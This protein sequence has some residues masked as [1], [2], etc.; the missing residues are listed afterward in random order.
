VQH[1]LGLNGISPEVMLGGLL[2]AGAP[3][4]VY[5]M[6]GSRRRRILE[7]LSFCPEFSLFVVLHTL[8]IVLAAP[9]EAAA[10]AW[11]WVPEILLTALIA[12][13]G[14]PECRLRKI[15]VIT[16]LV[17]LLAG[18]QLWIYPSLVQRKTMS[19]AKLEV[20]RFLRENTSPAS[21]GAMFDSGIVSYFS[22]RDFTGLNGLIGDFRHATL[23]RERKYAAAFARNGVDFMVLDTPVELLARL[24]EHVISTTAIETKFENFNEPPK[25]FAVYQGSPAELENIW[26]VRYK[27]CR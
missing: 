17:I 2:F 23:M 7:K 4:V 1:I 19:R 26:N 20:A 8:F 9:Q 6:T 27:G 21:R 5:F 22:Q 15:P 16:V 11:Y 25:P 3:V 14:L 18:I 12:G 10:S 24:K 13:A